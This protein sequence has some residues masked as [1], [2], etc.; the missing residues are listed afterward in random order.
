MTAYPA[1]V[2]QPLCNMKTTITNGFL[3]QKGVVLS[4]IP[5]SDLSTISDADGSGLAAVDTFGE[6]SF[7]AEGA[8][9][10]NLLDIVTTSLVEKY[11]PLANLS[12]TL[13]NVSS[14]SIKK[15]PNENIYVYEGVIPLTVSDQLLATDESYTLIV[16]QADLIVEG[17]L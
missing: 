11:T 12:A 8:G 2:S 15:V 7:F 4:S 10:S 3:L 5:N 16:T 13:L 9:Q 14:T 1:T 6:D 17:S